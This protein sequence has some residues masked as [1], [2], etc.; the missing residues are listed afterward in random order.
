MNPLLKW[1]Y[2]WAVPHFLYPRIQAAL[3]WLAWITLI[4]L[5]IGLYLG[6]VWAPPD[7]Q[8]GEAFRIIYVHVPAAWLS[9]GVYVAM[10]MMAIGV[11]VWRSKMAELS[12]IASAPIGAAFTFLA[13]V[14]GAIWGQPMWGTWWVWDA[15]LTSELI[16]L[17][18]YIGIYA[19]YEAIEDK[20]QAAKAAS[21][22]TLVGLI[23]I[24][25]IHYSVIWW[26]TLHQP[27]TLSKLDTP[28]IHIDMLIPLLVMLVAFKLLYVWML[29]VRLKLSLLT[30]YA[31]TP[32]VKAL[33]LQQ[34]K[35][36]KEPK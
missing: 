23:N 21:L 18:I 28:S 19:L 10:A 17:F 13:L 8:Q 35:N 20:R 7:Y 4:L 27:P 16:L 6:L 25:I 36:D 11:L 26:N 14:T 9:M 3:P 33:A 30:R 2:Q 1:C 5:A 22:M 24:P 32:W 15:R 29:M 31:H 34:V 12:L